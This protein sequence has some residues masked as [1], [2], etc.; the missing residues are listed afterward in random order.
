MVDLGE[1]GGERLEF[2][3]KKMRHEIKYLLD[4]KAYHAVKAAVSSVISA[5]SHSK[6]GGYPIRSLYFDD[7]YG[8]AFNEKESGVQFRQKYRVRIYGDDGVIKLERKEK[9]GNYISKQSA[10]VTK[11]Q[12]YGICEGDAAFLLSGSDMERDMFSEIRTK[13]LA[14][15]VIVDYYREAFVCAEGNVRITFDTELEAGVNTADIFSDS[16][17]SFPCYDHGMLL[18]E[19]KYDDYLPLYIKNALQA[20]SF[21]PT[22]FSKYV[23]CRQKQF[24]VYPAAKFSPLKI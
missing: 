11:E 10:T 13:R 23:T 1:I 17:M 12:F 15:A 2:N 21:T 18:L 5:D 9:L 3:G 22:A 8:T 7:M 6:N 16:V 4:M 20:G 24:A 19:V 14:P